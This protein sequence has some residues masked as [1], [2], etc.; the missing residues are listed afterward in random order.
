[1]ALQLPSQLQERRP[2]FIALK[3]SGVLLLF[4]FL[5]FTTRLSSKTARFLDAVSVSVDCLDNVYNSTLGVCNS[6]LTS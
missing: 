6:H 1:M 5:L 2:A 3:V 4:I